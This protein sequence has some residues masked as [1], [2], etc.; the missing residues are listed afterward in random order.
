M[1]VSLNTLCLRVSLSPSTTTNTNTTNTITTNTTTTNTTI[2]N[3]TPKVP[4]VLEDREAALYN[5]ALALWRALG[6]TQA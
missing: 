4:M 3:I 1:R 2:T 5:L 6:P